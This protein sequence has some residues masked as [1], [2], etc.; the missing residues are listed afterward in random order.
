MRIES[1]ANA[2]ER[3]LRRMRP[4]AAGRETWEGQVGEAG[5]TRTLRAMGGM[6]QLSLQGPGQLAGGEF[7]VSGSFQTVA[8]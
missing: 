7:P 6:G 2:E 3:A 1:Q 8:H 5:A 4:R